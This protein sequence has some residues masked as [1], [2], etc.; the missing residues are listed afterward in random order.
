MTLAVVTPLT[1]S[2][3]WTVA[4]PASTETRDAP[5][6]WLSFVSRVNEPG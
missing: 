3:K 2:S 5:G 4:V 6:G 1:T